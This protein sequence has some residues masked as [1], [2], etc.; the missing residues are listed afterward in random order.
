VQESLQSFAPNHL[1]SLVSMQICTVQFT[2]MKLLIFD[3]TQITTFVS[4]WFYRTNRHNKLIKAQK[5]SPV[6]RLTNPAAVVT[7]FWKE[8]IPTPLNRSGFYERLDAKK[9]WMQAQYCPRTSLP[10]TCVFSA[11][12]DLLIDCLR[13]LGGRY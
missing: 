6:Q 9:K 3:S 7:S 12:V 2:D 13:P 1:Y 11:K 5:K 8:C 4:K 10:R